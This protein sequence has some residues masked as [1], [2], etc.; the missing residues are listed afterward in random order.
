MHSALQMVQSVPRRGKEPFG[1]YNPQIGDLTWQSVTFLK[2][3]MYK[4][5]GHDDI[6]SSANKPEIPV[7]VHLSSVSRDIEIPSYRGSSFLWIVLD[8]KQQAKEL[9]EASL[10]K[11]HST[12]I[13]R[14]PNTF[15]DIVLGKWGVL[16][17]KTRIPDRAYILAGY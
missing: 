7:T 13:C 11:V 3:K 15:P 6:I 16:V 10:R 8:I 1:H 2:W 17:I 12:N 14:A 5:R 9:G 4:P